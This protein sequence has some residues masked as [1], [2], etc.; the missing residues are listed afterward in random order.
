[1]SNTENHIN[2][3]N[4]SKSYFE[5]YQQ[6][7][8]RAHSEIEGVRSVYKWFV[9]ILGIIS[10]I[11]ISA[12]AILTYNN[13]YDIKREMRSEVDRMKQGTS[14]E[15]EH[16]T[17]TLTFDLEKKV[18]EVEKEVRNRIEDE[19]DRENIR[20]LVEATASKRIKILADEI[21]QKHLR[22][23]ITPQIQNTQIKIDS[24]YQSISKVKES[25]DG[26]ILAAKKELEKMLE[27]AREDLKH[28]EFQAEFMMTV[29]SAQ[30]DNRVAW[31]R[32]KEWS[33]DSNF[34]FSTQAENAYQTIKDIYSN[35]SRDINIIPDVPWGDNFDPS[36]KTLDELREEYYK[37]FSYPQDTAFLIRQALIK[38]MWGRNDFA[39]RDRLDF[40]IEVIKI[41]KSL[42][43]VEYAGRIFAKATNLSIKAL[44][45]DYFTN[46]WEKNKKKY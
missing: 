22:Q 21:I 20:E 11:T 41:D 31:D 24:L 44:A 17:K 39:K 14:K 26:Q 6:I 7:V 42:R 27:I 12:V 45:V 2:E 40:L 16:L 18:Y 5:N 33:E 10:A 28:L 3:Q 30:N 9:S 4:D 13:V 34:P 37:A 46:W 8:D 29:L 32:L 43:V 38:Y 25:S 19:F 1:M 35:P 36:L 15:M 23:K